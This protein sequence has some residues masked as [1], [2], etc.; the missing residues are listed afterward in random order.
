MKV[1]VA[2]LLLLALSAGAANARVHQH[3]YHA[4]L[5]PLNLTPPTFRGS[6]FKPHERVTVSL[7]GPQARS[8]HVK[9]NAHGRFRVRLTAVSACKAWTVRAVG[10]RG[11]R[12]V[13]RH[14]RC[15]ALATDVEGTVTR[16]PIK[17]VCI[18]GIPCS[19]PAA[20]VTV[21]AFES[22]RLVAQ[23]TTDDNGR[24][25]FALAAGD[26]TIKPNTK[27]APGARKTKPQKVHLTGSALVQLSFSIDTGIR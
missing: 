2:A 27:E 11:G 15:A 23:T 4:S 17:N 14:A 13:Y 22:G 24:F 8:V 10:A 21:Q 18:E 3:R 12:A 26:Y 6:G 9:A 19:A 25:A 20:N 16:G 1:L 5:H 7:R